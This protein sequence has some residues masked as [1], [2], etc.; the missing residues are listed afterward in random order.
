MRNIFQKK[1]SNLILSVAIIAV[2]LV[3]IVSFLLYRQVAKV[4]S[5]HFFTRVYDEKVEGNLSVIKIE[6]YSWVKKDGEVDRFVINSMLLNR[7]TKLVLRTETADTC[8]NYSFYRM[9][10]LKQIPND[11]E[12]V[13]KLPFSDNYINSDERK[14]AYYGVFSKAFNYITYA[15]IHIPYVCVF[16]G[17][18]NFLSMIKTKDNVPFPS[19]LHYK[20]SIFYERGK[21]FNSNMV[22][23]AKDGF[24][25][26]VSYRVPLQDG[27]FIF[28]I[29]SLENGSYLSSIEVDNGGRCNNRD[30]E[31]LISDRERLYLKTE[32]GV[33]ELLVR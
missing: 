23:F 31:E 16:D 6:D 9:D 26:V 2:T 27:K 32:K 13:Y 15:F 5:R 7:K 8:S 33:F 20:N 24:V 22:S 14:M 3:V 21:T 10:K 11:T 18:G 17:A 19:L 1:H 12:C 29:Y 30:V 25:Y 4:Q 28:D